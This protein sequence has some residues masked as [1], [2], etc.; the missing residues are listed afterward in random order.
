MTG[1]DT[2]RW[3]LDLAYA[4][5][6]FSG[7]ATQPGLR[8]VQGTLEHWI[9]Q[10][11]RLGGPASLVCAGR[12]DAGVHARGQVAHLDLP[13][14]V[15]ATVLVRR[16]GRVLPPD[17]IVRSVTRAPDGFDARFAATWRRYCYRM[18]DTPTDPLHSPMVARVRGPIDVAAIDAAAP[19]LLGLHDFAAFC[20]HREGASTIRT[21]Q[22]VRAELVPPPA[23]AGP[24]EVPLGGHIAITV[25]ADAFCHSMVR[26]LVGAL[27]T[28]GTGRQPASWLDELLATRT[29]PSTIQVMPANGL[30]L[31]EVG[32]ADDLAD[33]VQQSRRMRTADELTATEDDDD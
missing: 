19:R 14:E 25:R 24:A 28:V 2:V 5:A 33:R 20:K 29:R 17:L 27:W 4:G 11:L 30:T 9:G 7:W 22:Q 8:T 21:L 26:S 23:G 12:T 3:R 31:E 6:D 15:D 1:P 10:V 13:A 16:L 32:Y 18:S